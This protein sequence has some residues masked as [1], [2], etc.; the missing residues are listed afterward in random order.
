MASPKSDI[1]TWVEQRVTGPG[2]FQG[3]EAHEMPLFVHERDVELA[4]FVI[5]CLA[6]PGCEGSGEVLEAIIHRR[7]EVA[8]G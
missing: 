8:G 4:A 7:R 3:F 5:R 6:N 2:G 1:Q